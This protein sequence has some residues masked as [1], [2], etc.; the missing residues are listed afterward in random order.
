MLARFGVSIFGK[1][2]GSWGRRSCQLV[3]HQL[4]LLLFFCEKVVGIACSLLWVCSF[5]VVVVVV[6]L[7]W[8]LCFC[9]SFLGVCVSVH[10]ECVVII[11]PGVMV[12]SKILCSNM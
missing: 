7:M 6:V 9:S 10:L 11:F 8:H 3:C 5:P 12:L 2:D 1:D 4:C